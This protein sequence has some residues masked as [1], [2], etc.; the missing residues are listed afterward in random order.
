MEVGRPGPLSALSEVAEGGEERPGARLG[1]RSC[2]LLRYFFRK[3]SSSCK[4]CRQSWGR[5]SSHARS[6]SCCRQY[7]LLSMLLVVDVFKDSL[8]FSPWSPTTYMELL[9]VSLTVGLA[10]SQPGPVATP[11]F[12]CGPELKM[13]CSFLSIVLDFSPRV[14]SSCLRRAT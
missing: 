2:R 9:R 13:E 8:N 10:G 12:L 5:D 11:A 6:P 3:A 7:R 14:P 1:F 4:Y